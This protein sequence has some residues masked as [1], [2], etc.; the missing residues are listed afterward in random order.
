MGSQFTWKAYFEEFL[1]VKIR[2]FWVN[3][4]NFL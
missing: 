1:V 2:A 4:I 3:E